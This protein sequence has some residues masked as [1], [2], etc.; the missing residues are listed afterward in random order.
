VHARPRRQPT[1]RSGCL[2]G[3]RRR[4]PRRPGPAGSVGLSSALTGPPR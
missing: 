4:R 2:G 1:G 3:F